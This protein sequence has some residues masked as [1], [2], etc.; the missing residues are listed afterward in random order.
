[1]GNLKK[2]LSRS[3]G[4]LS[5][6]RHY[7]LR[8][9]YYSLFNSHLIYASEIWG[10]NQPNQLLKRLLLLQEKA[11]GII[12]LQPQTSP[13][14]NLFK[15]NRIL[16]IS[17]YINYKYAIFVRNSLRK[18]NL[19]IFNNMFTPLGVKH[20]HNTRAATNHLLDIPRK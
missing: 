11:I 2:K 13:P 4:L 8:T 3:I 15:E 10:Q 9:L 5:K 20:T 19:Q 1:M 12:D 14:N 6:I 18:E 7:L 16:K 17:D